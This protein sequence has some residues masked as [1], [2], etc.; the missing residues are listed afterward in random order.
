MLEKR[1]QLDAI[2][3]NIDET[4]RDSDVGNPYTPYHLQCFV[5]GFLLRAWQPAIAMPA[6]KMTRAADYA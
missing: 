2:I 3:Q 1:V 6:A 4:N 5:R